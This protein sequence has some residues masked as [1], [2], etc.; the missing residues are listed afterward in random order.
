MYFTRQYASPWQPKVSIKK[1]IEHIEHIE[2]PGTCPPTLE[3]VPACLLPVSDIAS[4]E[5]QREFSLDPLWP[6][7]EISE[8]VRNQPYLFQIPC[9]Q[10]SICLN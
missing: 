8:I 1:P 7:N 10:D 3:N 2:S 9:R 6:G 5:G 4:S